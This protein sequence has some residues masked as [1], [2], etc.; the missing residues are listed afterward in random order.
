MLILAACVV[1]ATTLYTVICSFS[2]YRNRISDYGIYANMMWNT[3]HGH[4]FLYLMNGSYLRVHLSFTLGLFSLLYR[5]WDHPLLLGVLQWLCSVLGTLAVVVAARRRSMPALMTAALAFFYLGYRFTQ[6][7][8]V[9]DFHGVAIYLFL[10]PLLYVTLVGHRAWSWLP[11]LLILGLREDAGLV[12][13]PMLLYFAA[14]DRWRGGALLALAALL[15]S[16][17]TIL[18]LYPALNGISLF[19][20]RGA[21]MPSINWLAAADAGPLLARLHGLLLFL[22][23]VLVVGHRA[24]GPALLFPSFAVLQCLASNWPSQYAIGTHYSA[25]V[26]ATLVCG[27]VESL[28]LRADGR[29]NTSARPVPWGRT[30]ALLTAVTLAVHVESGFLP[31]GGK[32]CAPL[33]VLNPEG[34][35]T[36]RAA[37]HIPRDGVLMTDNALVAFCA[38]RHLLKVWHFGQLGRTFDHA[39]FRARDLSAH[40]R[41]VLL[42]AL[43]DRTLGVRYYDGIHVVLSRGFD[44]RDNDHVLHRRE[45]EHY[46]HE[47]LCHAGRNGHA[48][49]LRVRYWEGDGSRAPVSL[50]HGTSWNLAPGTYEFT[51]SY[52]SA[53]PRRS[54][55]GN[56][57]WLSVHRL[58]EPEPLARTDLPPTPATGHDWQRCDVRFTLDRPA[59]VEYRVTGGDARLWLRR[60]NWSPVPAAN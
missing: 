16:V 57:G 19:E 5:A 15:Y 41:G 3:A 30:A 32:S 29:P 14:R 13:L 27:L 49:G 50:A 60:V 44:P 52:R 26:M 59:A 38:N 8:H 45:R 12:V 51:L 9:H 31:G 54:V 36:L 35:A 42:Q 23:P 11:L 22:L 43:R 25:P 28:A 4:P 2:W 47:D 46:V 40:G 33:R 56:W 10:V 17:L 34:L 6:S 48:G 58:G 55:R 18:V 53:T 21:E 37:A 39:F 20:K 1:A 7:V 24:W